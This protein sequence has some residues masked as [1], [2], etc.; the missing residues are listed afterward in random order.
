LEKYFTHANFLIIFLYDGFFLIFKVQEIVF[1][2]SCK[3]QPLTTIIAASIMAIDDVSGFF[4]L[5]IYN[6]NNDACD[7]A[8]KGTH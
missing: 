5:Q 1:L 6:K 4:L 2:F 7:M 3:R 8:V